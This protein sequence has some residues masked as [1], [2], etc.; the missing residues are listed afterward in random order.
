MTVSTS[1]NSVTYVAT[2]ATNTFDYDFVVYDESHFVIT[3]D[4]AGVTSG[5]TVTG[6]GNEAGA[7]S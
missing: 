1:T 3:L 5:F 2:G 7:I 6:L 4:G